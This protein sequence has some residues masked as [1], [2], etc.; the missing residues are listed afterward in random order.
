MY[1]PE[2]TCDRATGLQPLNARESGRPG[3]E[4]GE[5]GGDVQLTCGMN[6]RCIRCAHA[7]SVSQRQCRPTGGSNQWR[8]PLHPHGSNSD[9]L[10]LPNAPLE[11]TDEASEQNTVGSSSSSAISSNPDWKYVVDTLSKQ[12]G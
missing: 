11:Q 4:I 9:A 12:T 5:V 2:F 3:E 6:M 8:P 10:V 7:S 1:A